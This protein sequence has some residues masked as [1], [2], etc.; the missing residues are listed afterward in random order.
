MKLKIQNGQG[1]N[2]TAE[3]EIWLSMASFD[4]QWL[5]R[6]LITGCRIF[7]G[8]EIGKEETVVSSVQNNSVSQISETAISETGTEAKKPIQYIET[9]KTAPK[10]PVK[11]RGEGIV[12]YKDWMKIITLPVVIIAAPIVAIFYVAEEMSL[13]RG[14]LTGG[15]LFL[16]IGSFVF[17]IIVG[18]YHKY[19]RGGII[20]DTNER[21]ISFPK[22]K[23]PSFFR[24]F[25]RTDIS[26]DDITGIQAVDEANV[27]KNSMTGVLQLIKTY[28][29][30][31]N[32]TWGSRTVRFANRE[33]RDQFY[34]LLATYGNFS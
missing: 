31:I 7:T 4:L 6:I 29:F 25:P 30:T 14:K 1:N 32:G 21:I 13:S 9:P 34:S 3:R 2:L 26:F 16:I 20:I 5:K 17:S 28:K 33:K 15:L 19:L 23:L 24:R 12:V 10:T 27:E 11:K 22:V 18:I 8:K